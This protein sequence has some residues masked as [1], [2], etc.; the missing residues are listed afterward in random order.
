MKQFVLLI[1]ALLLTGCVFIGKT[2]YDAAT[3][4]RSV[5][6]Q[7]DDG[8]IWGQ[9]QKDLLQSS[10]KGTD[11]ISI[12]CRN[13]IV[14][15][16]GVV[17]NGSE[18]GREAVRICHQVQG[19]KKVETYFRPSQRSRFMDFKIKE[20]IHFKMVGDS[21]LKAD[22]IDMKVLDG[23]VVLLGVVSSRPKVEKIIAI[24]RATNGVK[25]VKS[26]IQVEH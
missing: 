9:I 10:V 23:H 5:G 15:L 8:E 2:G 4:Q 16:V 13:G 24:A 6:K 22:Q 25:A 17:E 7:V 19:V 1:L 21:D 18:A 12:F 26:F 20:K 14:I 11:K 3:D